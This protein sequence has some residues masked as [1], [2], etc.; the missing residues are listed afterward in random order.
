[1][2]ASS[3]SSVPPSSRDLELSESPILSEL[4][5]H[6]RERLAVFLEQVHF[7]PGTVVVR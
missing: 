5:A 2:S 3:T 6:E 1:M 7:D 4:S